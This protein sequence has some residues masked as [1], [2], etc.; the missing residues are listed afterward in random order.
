[1]QFLWKFYKK[2]CDFL[3]YHQIVTIKT[4]TIFSL[5]LFKKFIKNTKRSYL[6]VKRNYRSVSICNQFYSA[7]N[8]YTKLFAFFTSI[9]Y[10]KLFAFFTSIFLHQKIYFFTQTFFTPNILLFLDKLFY[11]KYF[12]FFTAIFSHSKF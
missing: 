7:Q 9:F 12:T 6:C 11:T 1:M 10:I 3:F 8:F 2:C 5:L 4:V